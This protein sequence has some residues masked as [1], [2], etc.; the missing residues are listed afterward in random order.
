MGKKSRL[1]RRT[2]GHRW[3]KPDEVTTSGFLQIARFG[4]FVRLTNVATPAQRATFLERTADEHKKIALKLTEQ[5]AQLQEL[6]QKY[7]SIEL[8]HRAAYMV[9]PLLLKYR[10]EN[11]YS[12]EESYYLPAVE[13]LQYLIARTPANRDSRSIDETEWDMLWARVLDVFQ[14]TRSYLFTRRSSGTSAKG[15]DSFRYMIDGRRLGVRVQRYSIYF[16]DHLRDSLF[17]YEPSICEAYGLK[18]TQLIQGLSEINTY[19][20]TGVLNR[21][22]ELRESGEALTEKLRLQGY[23]T[24]PSANEEDVIRIREA[25]G[26]SEFKALHEDTTEKARLALTAAIFDVTEVT[27]LPQSV[28]GVLSVRAGESILSELTGSNHDDLSPLSN[29]IL[30]HKPLV[31]KDGRYYYFYHS[32]LEDRVAE[33]IEADLAKRFPKRAAS[34]LRR[35]DEYQ[36]SLA[37][38]LLAAVVNPDVEYRNL[39][40][41][42]PDNI[43][44]MTEVD[45]V[46]TLDD[47]L[48]IVEIKA[49]GLSAAAKRGAPESLSDELIETIGKGQQQSIRAEKYIRSANEVPFFN[50]TG[51]NEACRFRRH[52]FRRIFRVV[53]TREDLGWVGARIAALSKLDPKMSGSYPW[54]VSLDD[55]RVV[56]ELFKDSEL[57]FSHYLEQRLKAS[58]DESLAQ[59]D[60][61]EHVA[62]YNAMNHYH[63]RPVNGMGSITYDSSYMREIDS[64]FF[65]KSIGNDPE[66]PRQKIPLRVLNL[67]EALKQS[68]MRGRVEAASIIFSMDDMT[69]R[70]LD[71]AIDRIDSGKAQGRQF[72]ARLAVADSSCG[73][74]L[75]YADHDFGSEVKLSAA[76]MALSCCA[77]WIVVQFSSQSVISRIERIQPGR[78]SDVELAASKARLEQLTKET[79]TTERPGRNDKCPCGS[80]LK[81]KKCHGNS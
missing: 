79:I 46:L 16:E 33:I 12:P 7:D 13:Y 73:L 54:H 66:L 26:S 70:R 67:L 30:H 58:L 22:E 49:G 27:S 5:L 18:V 77:R 25:L 81:F 39:Y 80:G 4:R 2:D 52:D 72:S 56:G 42:D 75:T 1:K 76:Q 57:R 6:I 23:N 38:K 45:A 9:L 60:E 11:Q 78:F 68:R 21:Y 3:T 41:P 64:Y 47:V 71:D 51:K 37:T 63:E 55:L 29:S 69:R 44:G 19:Q 20:K 40:Y 24:D 50:Q 31:E 59:H 65:D 61:I 35:R 34:M 17:P 62:L 28:L 74:S 10:S 48:F 36:E 14:S 8:M 43:G 15:I 53:V 32:A